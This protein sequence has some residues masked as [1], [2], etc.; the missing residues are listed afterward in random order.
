MSL[1]GKS[2]PSFALLDQD[3]NRVTPADWKGSPVVLYFYPQDDTPT[4][5][6]QACAFR[7]EI[8]GYKALGARIVGISPDTRD[9]HRKFAAKFALPCTLLADPEHKVCKAYGVWREKTL[10]GRT[11]MGV[12]R[13][14]FLIDS[15]GKI[16]R[17]FAKVRV[18]GHCDA[19]LAALRELQASSRARASRK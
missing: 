2:A 1:E 15:T 16:R 11:Y 6:R 12:Q 17:V 7:D 18:N 19:V 4:C 14:T 9:S 13:T 10:F 8:T 3:G 5:T